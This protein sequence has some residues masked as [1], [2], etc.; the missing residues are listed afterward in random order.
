M[1]S[2]AVTRKNAYGANLLDEALLI[3]DKRGTV[4]DIAR[5]VSRLMRAAGC[6][7]VVIGGVA[8]VLHGHLRTTKD[9]D[10]F[11]N[12]PLK[13]LA[14]LLTNNGFSFVRA[15]RAFVKQGV[16]VHLVSPEQVGSA[17]KEAVEI[18]GVTTVTLPE[19]IGMKLRSGS[20]NPLRAQDLADVIGLIRH[21]RLTSEFARRLDKTLRAP[22]RKLVRLIQ[23]EKSRK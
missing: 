21:H 7:G 5:D 3:L 9:V 12:P 13:P 6:P 22:F 10:I 15:E 1:R 2:V 11:L 23:R 16:P 20:T 18:E 19:L 4:L 8:V 14:D 17:P